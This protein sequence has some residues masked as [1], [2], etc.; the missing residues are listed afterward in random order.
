M[1]IAK[2]KMFLFILHAIKISLNSFVENL[3]MLVKVKTQEKIKCKLWNSLEIMLQ[4]TCVFLLN[5]VNVKFYLII[6]NQMNEL[7]MTIIE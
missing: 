5:L 7:S 3:I 1:Q 4:K 2:K 6:N